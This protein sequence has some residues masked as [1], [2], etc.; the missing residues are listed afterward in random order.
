VDVDHG[1]LVSRRLQHVAIVMGLHKLAQVGRL[2]QVRLEVPGTARRCESLDEDLSI[3]GV[4]TG[5]FQLP[6]DRD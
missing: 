5:R 4:V 2:A 3:E 6:P 1:Q